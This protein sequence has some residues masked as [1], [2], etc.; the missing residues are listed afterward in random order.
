MIKACI[1]DADGTLL[2]SMG[3]WDDLGKRYLLSEGKEPER[4]LNQILFPMTMEESSS[5]LQKHYLPD[6]SEKEI[7]NGFMSMIKSSY[8]KEI[9][10]KRGAVSLIHRLYDHHIP[11]CVATISDPDLIRSALKRLGILNC[12]QAVLDT[13][14][15]HA[16]KSSPDIYLKACSL[17]HVRNSET[18]VFEDTLIPLK[19]AEKSGFHT[20][21]VADKASFSDRQEI[22]RISELY[23]SDFIHAD[24]IFNWMKETGD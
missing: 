21:A 19:T 2:D 7:Q 16:D 11:M 24:R 14:S 9:P 3:I 10:A 4:N 23:I 18:A 1:F 13:E 22:K 5:Y 6:L 17:M 15:L 12:F 8:E 20:V